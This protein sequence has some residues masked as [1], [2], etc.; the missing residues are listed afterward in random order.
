MAAATNKNQQPG[1]TAKAHAPKTTS[2]AQNP[3]PFEGV[4]P[5]SGPLTVAQ[6]QQM[7][8][9]AHMLG[10]VG[11]LPSIVIHR[12]ARNRARFTE[13]ESLEAANFTLAPTLVVIAGVLLGF[14]P[15]VGWVFALLAAAAWLLLA[16]SSLQAAIV[17]N[18]GRPFM[19]RFNTY[20]YDIV[21]RRRAERKAARLAAGPM[22]ASGEIV[23]VR[24]VDED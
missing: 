8:T 2:A 1:Q 3:T 6:D 18:K 16:F 23:G 15:Y 13:Q 11:C 17:V 22:T 19:Y 12:W 10:F 9:L 24:T 20:L 14:V 5:N 4:S 7:A 21:T